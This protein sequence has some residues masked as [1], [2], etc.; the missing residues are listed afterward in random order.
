MICRYSLHSSD[1]QQIFHYSFFL[2]SS[3][4]ISF[5]FLSPTKKFLVVILTNVANLFPHDFYNLNFKNIH[6]QIISPQNILHFPSLI[7]HS[8]EEWA[9]FSKETNIVSKTLKFFSFLGKHSEQSCGSS[10][11]S[12]LVFQFQFPIPAPQ[13]FSNTF[14]AEGSEEQRGKVQKTVVIRYHSCIKYHCPLVMTDKHPR[15]QHLHTWVIQSL[16]CWG[17]YIYLSQTLLGSF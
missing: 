4:C 16:I 8:K 7:Q 17:F 9:L 1:T 11:F 3:N 12:Q 2:I 15:R 14:R 10:L 6:L 5:L 13:V